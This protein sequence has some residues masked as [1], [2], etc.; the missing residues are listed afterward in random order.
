MERKGAR[1]DG[2]DIAVQDRDKHNSPSYAYGVVI[3]FSTF[4]MLSETMLRK[5]RNIGKP[6]SSMEE[7]L[8]L[9]QVN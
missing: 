8:P 1:Q 2:L 5:Y 9:V 6:F 3:I 7:V 4:T